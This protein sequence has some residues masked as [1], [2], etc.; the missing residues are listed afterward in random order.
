MLI[1]IIFDEIGRGTATFDGMALAHS[2]LEYL[3]EKV[4]CVTLFSTHYHEL[5]SLDKV[6]KRLKNVHVEAVE[7]RGTVAFLHKVID[8]PTDK[9]YGI[10]VASLAGLPKSL[11]ER[12][13]EVLKSLEENNNAKVDENNKIKEEENED[14]DDDELTDEEIDKEFNEAYENEFMEGEDE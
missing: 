1:F 5:T 13:K 8:G 3:H 11:I 10:N 7:E 12:S 9:S 14:E 2:I 4:G 6:L